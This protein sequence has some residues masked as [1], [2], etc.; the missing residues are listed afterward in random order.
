MAEGR[1]LTVSISQSESM[2]SPFA[3]RPGSAWPGHVPGLAAG[4]EA[5]RQWP[6][7][8]GIRRSWLRR[9]RRWLGGQVEPLDDSAVLR[10]PVDAVERLVIRPDRMGAILRE[11]A[12][13]HRTV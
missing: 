11:P 13:R 10:V 9:R 8:K 5:V 1:K 7:R 6:D 4:S 3:C 2:P 12:D